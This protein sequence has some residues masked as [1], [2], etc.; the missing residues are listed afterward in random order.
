MNKALLFLIDNK[1]FLNSI[2][3]VYM[4]DSACRNQ[5]SYLKE[6]LI[7]QLG[8]A[9]QRPEL[10]KIYFV[11]MSRSLTVRHMFQLMKMFQA[12]DGSCMAQGLII[13]ASSRS[14]PGY[15]NIL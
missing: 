14:I 9:N 6:Y 8:F 10:K 5:A 4:P 15:N 2:G 1:S 7:L 12:V 3:L 13:V 11:I